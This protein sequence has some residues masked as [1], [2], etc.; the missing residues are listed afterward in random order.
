MPTQLKQRIPWFSFCQNVFTAY[1]PPHALVRATAFGPDPTPA[2][3]AR[4]QPL[5]P[6]PSAT[7]DPGA[8]KTTAGAGSV[9]PLPD[10]PAVERPKATIGPV[11]LSKLG[12]T[13]SR[14]SDPKKESDGK[15]VGDP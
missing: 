1:E 14:P 4:A 8:R 7:L 6:V 9:P 2:G 5:T 13:N 15:Q 12:N 3:N 11:P 10:T